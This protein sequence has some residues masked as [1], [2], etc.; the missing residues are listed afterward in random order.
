M[1]KKIVAFEDA[2]IECEENYRQ[3]A[4]KMAVDAFNEGYRLGREHGMTVYGKGVNEN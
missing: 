4:M 1:D 3:Q 2:V